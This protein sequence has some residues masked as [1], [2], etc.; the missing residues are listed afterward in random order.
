MEEL[1]Y[2]FK[3]ALAQEAVYNSIL[4]KKRKRLHLRVA[5]AIE[6][7]FSERLSDFYGMLAF[8]FIQ[9]E[10]AD[11]AEEY[12]ERAG[13]AALDS[14]ASSEALVYY[15]QAIELYRNKMGTAAT[16]ERLAMEIGRRL[17]QSG[18]RHKTLD[19]R[20]PSHY[21]LSAKETFTDLGLELDVAEVKR[22]LS[23]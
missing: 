9:G 3:H 19:G 2:L 17:S 14:A 21:L 11:K 1:E 10:D 5:E 16:P 23:P 15:Q 20:S 12:L 4:L 8:H 18:T 7:S 13:Q 6:N 22:Y